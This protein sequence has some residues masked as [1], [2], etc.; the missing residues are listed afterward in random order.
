[1]LE[2]CLA[3]LDGV[4]GVLWRGCDFTFGVEEMFLVWRFGSLL[5]SGIVGCLGL[6][7]F[8]SK[9]PW[10]RSVRFFASTALFSSAGCLGV[11][12]VFEDTLFEIPSLLDTG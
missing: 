4:G 3:A 2:S 1:M 12:V 8:S 11:H 7:V 9:I 5:F 10:V 6:R